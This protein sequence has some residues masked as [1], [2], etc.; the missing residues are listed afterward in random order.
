MTSVEV[1]RVRP[2]CKHVGYRPR[3]T[4]TSQLQRGTSVKMFLLQLGLGGL[5]TAWCVLTP[6]ISG[7][8]LPGPAHFFSHGCKLDTKAPVNDD[9]YVGPIAIPFPL[10]FYRMKQSKLFVSIPT[11]IASLKLR[12]TT[13]N[14]S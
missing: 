4:I 14:L 11:E 9:G 13:L 1:L 6:G 7:K 12:V 3:T 10:R 5:L 2:G 8:S